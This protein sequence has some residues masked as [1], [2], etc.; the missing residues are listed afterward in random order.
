VQR[1]FERAMATGDQ[2]HLHF[3]K[4]VWHWDGSISLRSIYPSVA[5]RSQQ[6]SG[7]AEAARVPQGTSAALFAI[8][9]TACSRAA[10][11]E[12]S[13]LQSR[14]LLRP[15]PRA[16][17]IQGAAK[18]TRLTPLRPAPTSATRL[19]KSL[20]EH[21]WQPSGSLSIDNARQ[22]RHGLKAETGGRAHI[23]AMQQRRPSTTDG[24]LGRTKTVLDS[25]LHERYIS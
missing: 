10:L 16:S 5:V 22:L 4:P 7:S 25:P 12:C 17:G 15:R 11:R 1:C 21:I 9:T 20:R 14:L 23:P 3:E 2:S 13:G 8:I 6:K 18:S 19:A 24:H